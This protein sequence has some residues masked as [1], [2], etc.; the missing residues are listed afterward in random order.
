M[1]IKIEGSPDDLINRC[2]TCSHCIFED[3]LKPEQRKIKVLEQ[4]IPIIHVHRSI[5]EQICG[6]QYDEV[7]SMK[8]A[9]MRAFCDDRTAM[10][11]GV[12]ENYICDFEKRYKKKIEY[13]QAIKK[14]TTSQNLGRKE[15]ESYA[16]RFKEVWDRGIRKITVDDKM[17]ENQ[18]LT[19]DYIYEVIM[20]EAK[21]YEEILK[22]LDVMIEKHKERD[23]VKNE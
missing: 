8:Y 19:A 17:I 12:V 10:Q 16:K 1:R 13:R 7:C 9:A 4:S 22:I 6:H 20:M 15:K 14:W 23:L 3:I 21:L 2:D 18:I 11:F 5:I